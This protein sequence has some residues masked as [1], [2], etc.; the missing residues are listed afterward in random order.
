MSAWLPVL[1]YVQARA[2]LAVRG[3]QPEEVV[4]SLDLGRSNLT[5]V[6][7]EGGV[8][9]PGGVKLDWAQL[10]E[11]SEHENVC[12][13]LQD[14]E[15][16][17]IRGYSEE[18]QRTYQLMPTAAEP[19]LLIAGFVMHR[20][21]DVSPAEGARAMV[22]A[23]LPVRGRLLDTA[24]GLGYAAIEA[25][26]HA[27][28]VVTV[29]LDPWAQ[30]MARKNPWSRGLFESP[31]ITQLIGDSSA[32]ITDFP[33]GTFAAVVHDPPAINLAGELYSQA[34][35]VQAHRVLDRSGRMFHYI[36]DPESAS[37]GRVTKG[38][39]RRLQDAGFRKVVAKPAAFGVL[40]FK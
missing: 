33:S 14:G 21:R 40:A 36:G 1:S 2:L 9:F 28:E 24:T 11:V 30:R 23:V 27:S 7:T 16:R 34:F 31:K 20:I 39:V 32:L 37:G 25:A 15:F 29:E 26:E 4:A 19:A 10:E 13:E 3:K 17:P 12:F 18:L 38:V 35:Y 8:E 5:A 6:V 22:R